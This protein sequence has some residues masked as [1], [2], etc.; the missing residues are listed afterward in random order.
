MKVVLI[1]GAGGVGS[2]VAFSL[3]TS[4]YAYEV[5]LVDTRPEMI[6]SHVMDMENAVALGGADVQVRGGTA[7]DALDADIVVLCAAVPLRL[8]T[9]RT[10]YLAEN[11]QVVAKTLAPLRDPA[12]TGVVLMLTNPVD[13][14]LTWVY[15]QEW[16]PRQRLVGYTLNDS[17]RLRTGA[18]AALGVHPRDV[19]GWVLGEHGAGQ[20]PLYSRITV[21]G[22]PV[23]L[24]DVQR[25]AAQEYI[26]NWYIRH[27]AL[28]SGR[29]STWASGLGAARLIEA[30]SADNGAVLPASV[31]LEGEYGIHGVCLGAP[32]VLGR[33]GVSHVV[34]WELA[35]DEV[36]GLRAAA[37]SIE[38][39]VADLEGLTTT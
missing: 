33:Q 4:R 6:V 37:G 17:L 31:A 19:D 22:E 14:L 28:N 2:C 16:L 24:T 34:E 29:T 5:V 30:I 11:L 25:K 23:V 32:V 26:E 18:A 9:S 8:N 39:A 13:P 3:L 1:G 7:E 38:S 21:R 27:V 20:V 36:D 10:V 12:F 35:L 15:R